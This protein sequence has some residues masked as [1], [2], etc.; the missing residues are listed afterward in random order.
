MYRAAF[1]D[2]VT[3]IAQDMTAIYLFIYF[4]PHRDFLD[5][6][7]AHNPFSS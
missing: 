5:G 7:T 4:L 1:Y 6:P 3:P 2:T